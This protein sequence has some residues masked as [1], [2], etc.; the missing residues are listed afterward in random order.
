MN[1]LTNNDLRDLMAGRA[2]EADR[3]RAA[4][5][6]SCCD[7]CLLRY[8]LALSPENCMEPIRPTA[9]TV[10]QRIRL[11]L[12][13]RTFRRYGAA[14]AAVALAMLF[15]VSGLFSGVPQPEPERE[16]YL[17]QALDRFSQGTQWVLE[18]ATSPLANLTE[19]EKPIMEGDM[20]N[21]KE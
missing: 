10:I 7:E 19:T 4:E 21:E 3:L 13:D 5:H 15:W 12:A 6:L 1:H 2:S 9:P 16:N 8:T 17:T 14:V 20:I 11:R 18:Q